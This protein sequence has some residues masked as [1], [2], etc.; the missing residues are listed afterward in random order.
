MF[1]PAAASAAHAAFLRA[2]RYSVAEIALL[3]NMDAFYQRRMLM[4]CDMH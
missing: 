1:D 3:A 4:L 2:D